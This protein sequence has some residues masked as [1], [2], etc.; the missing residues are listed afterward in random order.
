MYA[1]KFIPKG[2]TIY[3]GLVVKVEKQSDFTNFL[4]LLPHDLQCDTLLWAFAGSRDTA[5]L[6]LD[7]RA[8]SILLAI[9]MFEC[10][11]F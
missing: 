2:R 7:E 6:V 11:I 10:F 9:T 5:Y 1:T 3:E 4:R 8:V